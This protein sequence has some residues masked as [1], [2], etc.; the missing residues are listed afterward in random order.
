MRPKWERLVADLIPEAK[1]DPD[2]VPIA[3]QGLQDLIREIGRFVW[4]TTHGAVRWKTCSCS[5]W[6]WMAGTYWMADA[7]VPIEATRLLSRS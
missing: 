5:T 3:I 1:L 2:G 4:C 7:P 6:G